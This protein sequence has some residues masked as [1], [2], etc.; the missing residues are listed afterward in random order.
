[1]TDLESRRR[2][3]FFG[4][5][6]R[7][8]TNCY[9]KPKGNPRVDFVSYGGHGWDWLHGNVGNPCFLLPFDFFE[10]EID[11]KSPPGFF[12][13]GGVLVHTLVGFLR[14]VEHE[15]KREKTKARPP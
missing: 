4:R 7:N 1:M 15:K 9:K 3:G 14:S 2:F 11:K 10:V 6:R 13:L 12:Q 5:L 8:V